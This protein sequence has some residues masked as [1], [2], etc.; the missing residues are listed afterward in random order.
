MDKLSLADG[1]KLS[2]PW[3][4]QHRDALAKKAA[5][6]VRATERIGD[7]HGDQF[8]PASPP[9]RR[10]KSCLRREVLGKTT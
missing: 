5:Y 7:E 3:R 1:R 10:R 6:L 2:G 9:G 4:K 8:R